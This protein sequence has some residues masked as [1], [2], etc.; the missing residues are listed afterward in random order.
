MSRTSHTIYEDT[1]G[2]KRGSEPEKPH[3]LQGI[4]LLHQ[5][6]SMMVPVSIQPV[7]S[8]QGKKLVSETK[9]LVLSWNQQ[10]LVLPHEPRDH[11]SVS[12]SISIMFLF[13]SHLRMMNVRT[14][15]PRTF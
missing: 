4:G 14:V 13:L 6:G 9:K 5:L 8:Q 3:K 2:F 7:C 1:G 11:Q 10:K 12:Y 15:S